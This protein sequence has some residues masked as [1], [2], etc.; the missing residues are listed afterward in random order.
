MAV[1][2]SLSIRNLMSYAFTVQGTSPTTDRGTFGVTVFSGSQ[3]SAS[4]IESSWTSYNSTFL[5][6]WQ[7][8]ILYNIFTGTLGAAQGITILNTPSLVTALNSGTASWCILWPTNP[9]QATIQGSSLPSTRFVVGPVSDTTSNGI[10]RFA[11]TSFISGNSY[12][13]NDANI[14]FSG[15]I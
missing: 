10:I 8:V 7:G 9:T 3:P 1:L 13:I 12:T 15:G 6:H 11:S 5:C 4:N 14:I 2:F